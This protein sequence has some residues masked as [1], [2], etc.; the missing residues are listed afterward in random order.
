MF[1]LTSRPVLLDVVVCI[2]GLNC[3]T[4]TERQLLDCGAV[5]FSE[6]YVNDVLYDVSTVCIFEKL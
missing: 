5:A 1:P 6:R 4:N 2:F 3:G